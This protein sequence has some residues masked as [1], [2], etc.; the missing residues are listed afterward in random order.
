MAKIIRLS[1][2][3]NINDDTWKFSVVRDD[4]YTE[5]FS[6]DLETIKEQINALVEFSKTIKTKEQIELENLNKQKEEMQK[7]I[8]EN[9]SDEDKLKMLTVFDEWLAGESYKV[10]NYVRHNN[11]LYKVIQAHESQVGWSPDIA[12]SLFREVLPPN[13]IGEWTQPTGGHDA[14][15]IG[16]SCVFNGWVYSCIIDNNVWDPAQYPQGWE[17]LYEV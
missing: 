10:D 9:T 14:Y 13:A 11:K 6:E 5:H 12:A 3:K 1:L 4:D 7:V 2:I 15:N 8:I 17:K 16:D